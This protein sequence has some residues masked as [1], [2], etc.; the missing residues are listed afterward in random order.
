MSCCCISSGAC[1]LFLLCPGGE[2]PSSARK[3]KK[4]H[5]DK[6]DKKSKDKKSKRKH[7]DEDGDNKDGDSD[8]ELRAYS[9]LSS[10]AYISDRLC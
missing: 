3:S 10:R 9:V 7:K 5:K 6:K 8:G 4:S 1:A 2:S